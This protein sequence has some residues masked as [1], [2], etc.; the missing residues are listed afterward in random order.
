MDTSAAAGYILAVV[1]LFTTGVFN[2]F[3]KIDRVKS[4][5][6]NP[7]IFN[8]YY[9][10][11]VIIFCVVAAITMTLTGKF[12]VAFSY[13][14]LI[15][16][17]ILGVG[18]WLIWIALTYMGMAHAAAI[19]SGTAVITAF[20][21]GLMVGNIPDNNWLAAIALILMILGT[22]HV[23]F[24]DKLSLESYAIS[25]FIPQKVSSALDS[26]K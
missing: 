22:V 18:G 3:V 8:I 23:Y 13:M 11:G 16:G 21:E 15:S 7:M 10:C 2:A 12:I 17:L 5:R 1:A 24:V 19:C 25:P 20:L 6:I 4:T 9:L 26:M 14:G